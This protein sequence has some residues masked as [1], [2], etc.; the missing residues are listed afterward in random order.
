MVKKSNIGPKLSMFTEKT[1]FYGEKYERLSNDEP[2]ISHVY[3][4]E[5]LSLIKTTDIQDFSIKQTESIKLE[6]TVLSFIFETGFPNES[7]NVE[8]QIQNFESSKLSFNGTTKRS[9]INEISHLNSEKKV[10]KPIL[11]HYI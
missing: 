8:E 6:T 9:M 5:L 10:M 1:T 3:H 2:E 11:L 4:S 7:G